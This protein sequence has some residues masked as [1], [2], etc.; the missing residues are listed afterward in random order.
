MSYDEIN[1]IHFLLQKIVT[2]LFYAIVGVIASTLLAGILDGKAPYFPIEISRVLATCPTAWR[3]FV[4]GFVVLVPWIPD[5]WSGLAWLCVMGIAIMDDERYW[6]LHMT[7]LGF[8]GCTILAKCRNIPVSWPF[9]ALAIGLYILRIVL[10]GLACLLFERIPIQSLLAK[11]MVIMLTGKTKS[12]LTLLIFQL[13]GVL[14]WIVFA[15][16]ISIMTAPS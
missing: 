5:W 11:A 15:I 16:V 12:T 9:L 8:L 7:F 10:K 6:G 13:G 14:Q 2:M 3:V 4:M 1:F